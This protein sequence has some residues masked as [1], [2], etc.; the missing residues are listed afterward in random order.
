M[1]KHKN[2]DGLD[3]L[4]SKDLEEYKRIAD[5][6][7]GNLSTRLDSIMEIM[8]RIQADMN[9]IKSTMKTYK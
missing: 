5:V 9:I 7:F 8:Q 2:N 1:L 6:F 4:F 3:E